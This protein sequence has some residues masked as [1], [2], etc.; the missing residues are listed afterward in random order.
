[1]K[2]NLIHPSIIELYINT[3][4]LHILEE[5][6]E[7]DDLMDDL[8]IDEIKHNFSISAQAAELLFGSSDIVQKQLDAFYSSIGD[9]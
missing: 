1:M 7:N 8:N 5:K 4:T 3:L 2:F 9:A 6:I